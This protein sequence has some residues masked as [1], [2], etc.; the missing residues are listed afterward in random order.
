MI[1]VGVDSKLHVDPILEGVLLASSLLK[2]LYSL[3]VSLHSK[4]IAV[5]TYIRLSEIDAFLIIMVCSCTKSHAET[6]SRR[7]V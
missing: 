7:N 6:N 1:R 3:M 5:P 2:L 4:D